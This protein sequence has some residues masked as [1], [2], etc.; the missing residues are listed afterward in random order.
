MITTAQALAKYGQPNET[1]T[2]L[3][4]IKLPYP[5]RIAWDTKTMVTKMRC[6]KLVADAFLNVFNG[7]TNRVP[8]VPAVPDLQAVYHH[9]QANLL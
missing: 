5:M 9:R 2:Y 7:N 1:G 4:T 8:N 6:H 3:T